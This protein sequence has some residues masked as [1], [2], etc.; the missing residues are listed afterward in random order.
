MGEVA[1]TAVGTGAVAAASGAEW[2]RYPAAASG[3][4]IRQQWLPFTTRE[5]RQGHVFRELKDLKT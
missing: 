3:A 2:S 4:D 1:G 5:N